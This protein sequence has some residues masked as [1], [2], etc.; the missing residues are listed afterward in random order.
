MLTIIIF[1][2]VLFSAQLTE[3]SFRHSSYSTS[4]S[5]S[6]SS[7]NPAAVYL[8]R[9]VER[10]K[11]E[12]DALLKRHQSKVLFTILKAIIFTTI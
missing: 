10:K 9:M 2:F 7:T 1:I 6:R 8:E 12:V 11:I 5:S 4:L 3:S